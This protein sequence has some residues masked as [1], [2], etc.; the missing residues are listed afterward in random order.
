[1][2][3]TQ[4]NFNLTSPPNLLYPKFCRVAASDSLRKLY[5]ELKQKEMITKS[6]AQWENFLQLPLVSHTPLQLTI[7]VLTEPWNQN[8][9][10]LVSRSNIL[11][12]G[13]KLW[14]H[15]WFNHFFTWYQIIKCSARH[16]HH[17]EKERQW[18]NQMMFFP[19]L[20]FP[21][22]TSQQ[23]KLHIC[24]TEKR[25]MR[26]ASTWKIV[27]KCIQTPVKWLIS[28]IFGP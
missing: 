8:C 9:A 7:K 20:L 24:I 26:K 2:Y 5:I 6:T 21:P 11:F 12:A 4:S 25:C 16:R 14:F 13:V 18:D 1:M 10:V 22:L 19:L 17:S 3:F 28:N 27:E 23:Q 15:L